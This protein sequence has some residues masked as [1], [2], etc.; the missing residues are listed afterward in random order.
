MH[1]CIAENCWRH[2]QV[3]EMVRPSEQAEKSVPRMR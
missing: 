2:A 1:F 3:T